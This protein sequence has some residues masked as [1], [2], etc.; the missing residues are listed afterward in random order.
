MKNFTKIAHSLTELLKKGQTSELDPPTTEQLTAFEELK[1]KLLNPPVLC[2]PWYGKPYVL[3][4]DAS[5][6]QLGCALLQEQ[7]DGKLRPVGYWSRTL[8][9]AEKNYS[10]SERE[11]LGVVW[12]VLHLR[13]YLE[14]TRFTVRTDH[15]AL[16]WLLQ[17]TSIEGRL[18]RWRL[19]L[20]E[21]DFY[22]QYS[23]GIKHQVPDALSRVSTKGVDTSP[24]EEDIP[25][26]TV[27]SNCSQGKRVITLEDECSHLGRGYPIADFGAAPDGASGIAVDDLE[28][29]DEMMQA[30]LDSTPGTHGLL[31]CFAVL[32]D[33][34]AE[35]I[36]IEE[37]VREQA[38]DD[39]CQTVRSRLDRGELSSTLFLLDHQGILVRVSPLDSS[40]QVIV[41]ESLRPRLLSSSHYV[42]VAGHPGGRRMYE[43]MRKK[44]YWPSMVWICIPLYYSVRRA[45]AIEWQAGSTQTS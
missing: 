28:L 37:W 34:W 41:P 21:Y 12:S 10:A 14:G 38:T 20:A 31:P 1:K 29:I 33:L 8:A 18:A 35:P 40:H 9:Q 26:F 25:C 44:F 2:L 16:N 45:H 32:P 6:Y 27:Q 11:C 39:Y 19:R 5:N 24:C 42:A 17:S 43:T 15:H 22:I 4:V 7:D 13:P 3:D 23:P 30:F 36:T